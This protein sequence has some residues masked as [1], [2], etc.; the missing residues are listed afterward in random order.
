MNY[1][2]FAEREP[3]WVKLKQIFKRNISKFNVPFFE[4]G[5]EAEREFCQFCES[6][7]LPARRKSIV[8][9]DGKSTEAGKF[10]FLCVK[11]DGA[12]IAENQNDFLDLTRACLGGGAF[13]T[14]GRAGVQR[15]SV[16]V[17][18]GGAERIASSGVLCSRHP[19]VP[20]IY[21]LSAVVADALKGAEATGCEIISTNTSGCFQLR[22]TA[23]PAGPVRIGHARMGNRCPGCGVAK[24]FVSDSERYFH[25][26]DLK[27][28]DFQNCRLYHA[29]N[30][31]QFEILNGFP[32]VSERIF[33]LLLT[34]G[35]KG[36]TSY[37][38]DPPIRHAVVQ[39]RDR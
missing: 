26:G 1:Y 2:E 35:V 4:A 33:Y 5:S 8:E 36:L 27:L 12:S 11:D 24:M 6:S 7:N 10:V 32:I 28:T 13:G 22:I 3:D 18:R 31:G 16:P 29:D 39:V 25:A 17:R 9:Y 15:D 38:T 21:L 14:C 30:I 20:R 23:E 37:S 34:L 19:N